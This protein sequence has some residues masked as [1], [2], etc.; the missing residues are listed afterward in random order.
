MP[1]ERLHGRRLRCSWAR[2]A[3]R[4]QT[5]SGDYFMMLT[6]T[7]AL[8]SACSAC[9]C[10]AVLSPA[11]R[12]CAEVHADSHAR[13]VQLWR[14]PLGDHHW[15]DLSPNAFSCC[16]VKCCTVRVNFTAMPQCDACHALQARRLTEAA[17]TP[18]GATPGFMLAS[19]MA[20]CWQPHSCHPDVTVTCVIVCVRLVAGSQRGIFICVW[21]V[22]GCQ[23]TAAPASPTWYGSAWSTR[24]PGGRP[25]H[26]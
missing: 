7:A 17:C 25:Q 10:C 5:S 1:Q 22:A 14:H 4:R 20:T 19:I 3:V 2:R 11:L 8:Q 15:C 6:A 24:P 21:P 16:N 18:S 12:N 23:R 13:G 26:R 9:I